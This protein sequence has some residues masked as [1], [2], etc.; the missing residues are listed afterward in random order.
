MRQNLNFFG[1]ARVLPH[2]ATNALLIYKTV[3]TQKNKPLG[4]RLC[5]IYLRAQAKKMT[6]PLIEINRRKPII[7]SPSVTDST[8]YFDR[9]R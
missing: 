8:T 1:K 7:R 3:F 2:H 5:L 4:K 6:C 9:R